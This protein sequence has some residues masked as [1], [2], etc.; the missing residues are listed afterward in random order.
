MLAL[1]CPLSIQY[2]APIRSQAITSINLTALSLKTSSLGHLICNRLCILLVPTLPLSTAIMK[3]IDADN[4]NASN[5]IR[6]T[7]WLGGYCAIK[8]PP[9]NHRTV[10]A[11]GSSARTKAK[12]VQV[13]K[14]INHVKFAQRKPG[15]WSIE[16]SAQ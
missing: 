16:N 10:C 9:L 3:T 2:R 11:E 5:I 15:P 13:L 12:G 14:Q 7:A 8:L 1:S 4:R 6:Q